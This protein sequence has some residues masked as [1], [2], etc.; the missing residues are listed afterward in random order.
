[1][2]S[3]H[4]ALK[5]RRCYVMSV[6]VQPCDLGNVTCCWWRCCIKRS[7][8]TRPWRWTIQMVSLL[9]WRKTGDW[10]DYSSPIKPVMV[11]GKGLFNLLQFMGKTL[12]KISAFCNCKQKKSTYLESKIFL[13]TFISLPLFHFEAICHKV[14]WLGIQL[15]SKGQRKKQKT[16]MWHRYS[17]QSQFKAD[18]G[19]LSD[20]PNLSAILSACQTR[21]NE[22]EC[23]CSWSDNVLSEVTL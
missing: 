3:H 10:L 17:I 9:S 2:F 14:W 13:I 8:L 6:V 19:A 11:A 20:E 23:V 22:S 7:A 16:K 21:P 12:L 5:R 4:C 18:W 15:C 1:M